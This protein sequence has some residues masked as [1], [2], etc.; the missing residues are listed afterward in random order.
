MQSPEA[1][2][3]ALLI[4][5]H[6]EVESL[7][8][9]L[10]KTGDPAERATRLGR[11]GDDLAVHIGA[12]EAVFYPVVNAARTEGILLESL[13][14][15]LSLKRLLA[16][17][18]DLPPD[19]ATFE[20][21]CHVLLEQTE[22]HHKEEEEHLFPTV[23]LTLSPQQLARLHGDVLAHEKGLRDAGTPRHALKSQTAAAAS[24]GG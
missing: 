12:E 20:A 13:E 19:D 11:A 4:R 23:R 3:V 1:D 24:P 22:H 16:D 8:Q 14:E 2:V 17:L 5:Q 9:A 21:K 10:L 7:L 18:L 15:H 6:R